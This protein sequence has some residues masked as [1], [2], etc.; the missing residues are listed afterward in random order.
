MPML[1]HVNLP[2]ADVAPLRDF[3]ARYFKFVPIDEPEG[4]S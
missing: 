4:S 2:A 1:N 3:F